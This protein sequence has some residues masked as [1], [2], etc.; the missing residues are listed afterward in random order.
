MLSQISSRDTLGIT[1]DTPDHN[2][3]T[4][5]PPGPGV[6]TIMT[7]GEMREAIKASEAIPASRKAYLLWALNRTTALLGHGLPDVRADPKTVLRQLHR[8]SPAMAGLSPQSFANLKSLVRASLQFFAPRIAGARSRIK[9]V[10]AWKELEARLPLRL[11]RRL[12]QFLRFAQA[13]GWLPHEIGEEHVQR[14]ADYLEHEVMR[15]DPDEV[16]RETRRAWN[17][18]L[19]TVPGWPD[20]RLAPPQRKRQPYWLPV[21]QLPSPL[22]QEMRDYL[23]G[24]GSTDPFLGRSSKALAQGTMG[25][26]R[27][28]FIQLAS[29]LVACGTPVGALTSIKILVRPGN[30]EKALRFM[31][32]RAGGRVNRQMFLLTYRAHKIALHIGLP[33]PELAR[34]DQILASV[35][36]ACP[37]GRGLT[38]KNRRLLENF[39]DPAFVDRLVTLPFKLMET[40]Q[41]TTTISYAASR[42]RDAVAIELLLTCSM[43]AGNL[44]DL[45]IGETI[46]RYGE[47]RQARWV[48]DIPG[49]RVKNGQPLRYTLLPDSGRL[50]EWYLDRWQHYWCGHGSAW[51]F[52]TRQGRHIDVRWLS[53]TIAK[54]THRYVGVPITCHQF[55]HLAAELY[56]REDPNGLGIV[57]QHLGHRDLNT[58]RHFYAREQTRIATQRYHQVLERKRAAVP[59][60]PRKRGGKAA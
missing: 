27:Y 16:V 35:K 3:K 15:D 55:R 25:H 56:L 37:A 42:A 54:R 6:G 7:L 40:A 17:R 45:R 11:K 47:G 31:Y 1:M 14:F 18:A 29:A 19:E 51:L 23:D 59:S 58:A 2:N 30:I 9:L 57:S 50:I 48:V 13:N 34:L 5:S 43:R 60:R 52:P 32:A 8:L 4:A 21:E 22:Q 26:F 46:R 53:D 44:V 49:E 10:G 41:R 28:V 12:S 38:A 20:R 39:E 33:A 36:H 24:L